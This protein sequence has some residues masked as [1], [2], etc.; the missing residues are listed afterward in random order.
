MTSLARFAGR[1]RG[2][3]CDAG[4]LPL[5]QVTAQQSASDPHGVKRD[6]SCVA[7]ARL[8]HERTEDAAV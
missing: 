7:V 6:V 3:P 2:R 5:A 4:A 1:R 8:V